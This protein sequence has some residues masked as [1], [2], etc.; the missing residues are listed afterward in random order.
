M[1]I[2][3]RLSKAKQFHVAPLIDISQERG[4]SGGSRL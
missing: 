2:I 4:R 3:Y 1:P